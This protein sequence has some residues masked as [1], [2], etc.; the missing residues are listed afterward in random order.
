MDRN[1]ASGALEC[2]G[3][4]PL[5]FCALSRGQIEKQKR[6]QTAALQKCSIQ[7]REP[8]PAR[9]ERR[10]ELSAE[11]AAGER[12]DED[13]REHRREGLEDELGVA[14]VQADD[15][16]RGAEA[17]HQALLQTVEGIGAC[18]G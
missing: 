10:E 14:G 6:R 15:D 4:T 18:E 13:R 8:A 1:L 2:G 17:N 3:L 7:R 12:Q 9:E 11:P 5:L 16:D